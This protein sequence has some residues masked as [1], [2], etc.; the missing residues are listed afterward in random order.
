MD[1]EVEKLVLGCGLPR[2]DGAGKRLAA[3]PEAR[4]GAGVAAIFEGEPMEIER[5]AGGGAE[6]GA[7]LETQRLVGWAAGLA[8][9]RALERHATGGPEVIER[10]PRP[11]GWDEEIDVVHRARSG[12]WIHGE[13]EGQA[14]E[15]EVVDAAAGELG[16]ER[17]KVMALGDVV[18]P[19]VA[20]GA[21]E[22]GQLRMRD[23]EGLE[24]VKR[25]REEAGGGGFEGVEVG[26]GDPGFPELAGERVVG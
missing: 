9:G 6:A 24:A 7:V 12:I 25:E 2:R 8:S 17:R 26:G 19:R 14:F 10:F 16:D 15:Q 23:T 13:G 21:T 4:V 3:L 20:Q 18:G 22:A 5:E 1:A 11:I